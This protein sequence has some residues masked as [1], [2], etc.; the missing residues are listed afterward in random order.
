MVF[1]LLKKILIAGL[2]SIGSEIV[3]NFVHDYDIKVIGNKKFFPQIQ[4]KFPNVE[5]I[6][7]DIHTKNLLKNESESVDLIFYVIDTGGVVSCVE[8]PSK[9][10]EI[11]I[12]KFS[13][14]I[15]SL[16]GIVSHFFLLSTVFVYPSSQLCTEETMP[17]PETLYGKFRLEQEQILR[18][19]NLNFTILR[20]SN[21]F[22]YGH[23]PMIG[24]IGAI[25]KFVNSVFKE[26]KILLHGDGTQLVDYLY[27]RDLMNALKILAT[28]ASGKRV[29]N[30]T[31]GTLKTISEIAEIITTIAFQNFS[32][33][34]EIVKLNEKRKIPSSPLVLSDKIRK[35]YGWKPT[36][37]IYRNIEEMMNYRMLQHEWKI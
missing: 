17:D 36:T 27:K 32:K 29:Y 6:D 2:G 26:K 24:N 16:E 9:Y 12:T 10:N 33:I 15:K 22:G 20:L 3:Y 5:L 14:L 18:N 34:I 11:N 4:T 1:L 30:I 31:T 21:I 23:F 35:E 7:G 28:N 19:S 37:D 13:K 25:E 8:N